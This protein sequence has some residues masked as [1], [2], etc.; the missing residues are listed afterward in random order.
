MKRK[1]SLIM[2]VIL[3]FFVVGSLVA[4]YMYLF[5]SP[6]KFHGDRPIKI[7]YL[8]SYMPGF[9]WS[10]DTLNSFIGYFE[11]ENIRIEIK[12]FYMNVFD[13]NV[14]QA[15][16]GLAAKNDIDSWQPDLIFATDDEAQREVI[17]K[18]YLNSKYPVV[19][20]AVNLE[21]E[22]YGYDR[23]KNV[24]GVLEREQFHN[25]INYLLLV[26]PN[27]KK[28]AVM[29]DGLEQ[30]DVTM[31][32]FKQEQS[33]FPDIQFVGW[34]KYSSVEEF[35]HDVLAYQDKV[36]ALMLLPLNSMRYANGTM[37]LQ[38]DNVKWVVENSRLPEIT[39]WGQL[40]NFGELAAVYISPY[41]Q[42]ETSAKI[43]KQILI[44]G[45][46]PNSFPIEATKQNIKYFN[47]ARALMLGLKRDD[48]PSSVLVNS[49][50]VTKF[51]WE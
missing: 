42:G 21:P 31:D 19:F 48:I 51:P 37:S 10:D 23:A 28:I 26:Y 50:V 35:R 18:Y 1:L 24:A 34:R 36:D 5:S 40:V 4:G 38:A 30:W 15:A 20:S 32:R 17:S 13:T 29:S 25:A 16:M 47:L 11:E 45:K 9:E 7:F 43:A 39:F 8:S 3:G 14:D 46:R 6:Y 12:R 44:D 49:E 27:V 22:D 2:Y 41:E 33:D